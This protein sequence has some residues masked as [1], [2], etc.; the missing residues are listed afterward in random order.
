MCIHV[1]LGMYW[2]GPNDM[3]M[4]YVSPRDFDYILPVAALPT[5]H[6]KVYPIRGMKN[7]TVWL[8]DEGGK[9]PYLARST[10]L[11]SNDWTITESEDTPRF[12]FDEDG[13]IRFIQGRFHGHYDTSDDNK[14]II[15]RQSIVY[16]DSP[17]KP[18]K[19]LL[20]L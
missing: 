8:W 11:T 20:L 12:E 4:I 17:A 13:T 1:W 15:T 7:K 14:S 9:N 19:R 2:L 6:G 10:L 3:S 16:S 18:D 5:V